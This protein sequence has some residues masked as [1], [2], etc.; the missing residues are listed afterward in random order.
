MHT[1]PNCGS[2]L[3]WNFVIRIQKWSPSKACPSCGQLLTHAGML[4]SG[5]ASGVIG[6]S[7]Y[8]I[9][10]LYINPLVVLVIVLS[11]CIFYVYR[12]YQSLKII[13]TDGAMDNKIKSSIALNPTASKI[14][15]YF[16]VMGSFLLFVGCIFIVVALSDRG[17]A[18]LGSIMLFSALGLVGLGGF[19]MC[20]RML[21]GKSLLQE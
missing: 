19:I 11:G 21:R 8:Q 15:A 12:D 7:A 2:L 10:K 6:I 4:K 16:G 17:S 18:P 9:M 1:C 20:V 3:S 5:G 13:P 14:T